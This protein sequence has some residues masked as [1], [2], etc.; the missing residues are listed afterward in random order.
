MVDHYAVLGLQR[1]ATAEDIKKAYRK[2]ALRWHPDKNADKKDLAERK[3]KDISAAFKVLS[4]PDE[5]AHYDLRAA[6]GAPLP[7]SGLRPRGRGSPAAAR[8]TEP[9]RCQRCIIF[10]SG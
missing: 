7:G 5:R 10:S 3:F 8:R 1:N 2:E 4:D 6:A 9:S